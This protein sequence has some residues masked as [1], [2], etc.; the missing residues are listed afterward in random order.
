M[1]LD[2]LEVYELQNRWT[3]YGLTPAG[4]LVPSP[5]DPHVAEHIVYVLKNAVSQLWKLSFLE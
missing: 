1:F 3:S 5:L 2:F 4:T